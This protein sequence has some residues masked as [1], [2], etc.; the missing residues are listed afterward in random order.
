MSIIRV[1]STK[2]T[3]EDVTSIKEAL[4]KIPA[5]VNLSVETIRSTLKEVEGVFL[6]KKGGVMTG[7]LQAPV[8]IAGSDPGGTESL[9]A[10]SAFFSSLTGNDVLVSG[11]PSTDGSS[12]LLI[13]FN[14]GGTLVT[15]RVYVGDADS[16]GAGYRVLRVPN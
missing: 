12:N 13:V 5:V 1:P 15:K 3:P 8:I 16:G 14:I 7:G 10:N 2:E 11:S 4:D 9:R 6:S